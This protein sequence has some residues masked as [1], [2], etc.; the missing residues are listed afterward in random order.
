MAMEQSGAGR[1]VCPHCNKELKNI[2]SL[3]VHIS[4]YHR[5][6]SGSS[7]EVRCPVCQRMYSNK[8]SLRTHMHLNHKEQLHLIG[9]GKKKSKAQSTGDKMAKAEA[10]TTAAAVTDEQFYVQ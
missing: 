2:H 7:I 10:A 8:Y 6:S 9:S 3:T 1:Q 4:R 5:E